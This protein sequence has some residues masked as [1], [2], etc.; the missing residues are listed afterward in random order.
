VKKQNRKG[1]KVFAMGGVSM[2]ELCAFTRQLAVMHDAGIPLVQTVKDLEEDLQPGV[3]KNAL[4]DVVF[5]I[6]SGGKQLH[7]ALTKHPKCFDRAYIAMVKSG[8]ESG[9]LPTILTRLADQLEKSQDLKRQLKTAMIYPI[10]VL[11]VAVLIVSG[12]MAFIIPKFDKIFVDMGLTLPAMTKSLIA[13]SRWFASY[14]YVLPLFP[15]GLWGLCK[16]IRQTKSGNYALDRLRLWTPVFGSLT[17]KGEIARTT[18]MLSTLAAT[19]VSILDALVLVRDS[20]SNAV[21]ARM[22]Q[23]VLEAATQGDTLWE[24]FKESRL[25]P[26]MV[27]SMIK[28]GENS[29]TLD[30]MLGKVADTFEKEVDAAIKGMMS[31]L[32]PLMTVLLGLL[33]G[34]I[35]VSLFLPLVKLLEGLSK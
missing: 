13:T 2:K 34:V 9:K 30:T 21:F 1:R 22:Y 11:T 29:G 32:E 23:R 7:E 25:V 24:A 17:S 33:V 14:W 10:A 4:I 15:L 19:H 5:D 31:L 3:L 26:R 35:V 20:C 8:E 27:V 6:E 18:R 16:A 12:I 28:A